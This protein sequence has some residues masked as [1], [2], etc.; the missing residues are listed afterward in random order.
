MKRIAQL[1][2]L[3]L[4]LTACSHK[5]IA[6]TQAVAVHDTTYIDR[7]RI[8]SLIQHDSIYTTLI[9]R[10][11]TIYQTTYK[12]RYIYKPT[13]RIDSIYICK[14]DTVQTTIVEQV[15]KKLSLWQ[16]V[17]MWGGRLLMASILLLLALIGI[18]YYRHKH[19]N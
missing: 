18:E 4:M 12:E 1:L 14:R 5:T 6:P 19:S 16:K 15:E 13:L 8:D 3:L 10:G 2:P 17:Q 11:E 7:L 9:Q